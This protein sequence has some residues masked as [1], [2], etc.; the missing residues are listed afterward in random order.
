MGDDAFQGLSDEWYAVK[1]DATVG[2]SL[3]GIGLSMDRLHR[4]DIA[5]RALLWRLMSRLPGPADPDDPNGPTCLLDPGEVTQL[6]GLP[7]ASA[8]GGDLNCLYAGTPTPDGY[9]LDIR[10]EDPSIGSVEA[11]LDLVS[12]DSGEATTVA[13]MPAW[14]SEDGLWVD[15]GVRLL[16]VQPMW[17][18]ADTSRAT[19]DILRSIAESMIE[20]MPADLANPMPEPTLMGDADLGAL[21]PA[22]LKGAPVS[23][24]TIAGPAIAS[25]VGD[26]ASI[27]AVLSDHGRTIDDLSVAVADLFNANDR[28]GSIVAIRLRGVDAT[29]FGIPLLLALNGASDLPIGQTPE[30]IGGKDVLRLAVPGRELDVP[31]YLWAERDV[32][33]FVEAETCVIY[34]PERGCETSEVDRPLLEEILGKLP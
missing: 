2:L 24:Q 31:L 5:R 7:F 19:G 18:P 15:L 29:R 20:R 14:I 27:E 22:E 9:A 4:G 32:A 17:W 1:G 16:V 10:L 25:Q 33:W 34:T 21:F 13:E 8:S 3:L 26:T 11:N 30:S 23:V 12:L 6:S 28:S